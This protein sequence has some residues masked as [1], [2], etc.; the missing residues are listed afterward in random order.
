MDNPLDVSAAEWEV[1]CELAA[2]YRLLAHFLGS[3]L[4]VPGTNVRG[5]HPP[6]RPFRAR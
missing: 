4:R 6:S 1:R 3:T 2:L 5:R